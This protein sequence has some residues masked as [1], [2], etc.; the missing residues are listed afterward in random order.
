LNKQQVKWTI[1]PK[2]NSDC[3]IRDFARATAAQ[4]EQRHQAHLG[5]T[6]LMD[7]S[8]RLFIKSQINEANMYEIFEFARGKNIGM[9]LAEKIP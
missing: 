2:F 5:Y 9:E 1:Y 6:L 8:C 3:R 7:E 4:I